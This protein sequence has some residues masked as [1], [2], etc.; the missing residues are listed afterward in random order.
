M[1]QGPAEDVGDLSLYS[2]SNE[3][4]FKGFKQRFTV[5][6]VLHAR[7]ELCTPL[8]NSVFRDISE[9]VT[10]SP[11]GGS[12]Y[13]ADGKCFTLGLSPL[14]SRLLNLYLHID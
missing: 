5:S 1:A 13:T 12:M 8:P 9:L 2:E 6:G 4:S 3:K 14:T 11:Y 10:G 7:A